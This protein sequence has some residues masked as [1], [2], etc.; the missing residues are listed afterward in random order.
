MK[1][2]R[3][4]VTAGPTREHFDPVRFISNPSSGKMGAA[5]ARA[6]LGLGWEVSLVMGPC[7]AEAPEGAELVRVTSA[8]DMLRETSARFDS[9]DMLIMTAAVSD[10]RPREKSPAKVKKESLSM[11]VEFEPTP[12]I[13]KT[14]SARKTG[15]VLVGFAA[16]TNDV[17]AYAR[18][19]LKSKNLDAIAANSVASP[20]SG[21]A[22]DF[23][24]ITLIFKDGEEIPLPLAPKPELAEAMAAI[25]ARKF[26]RD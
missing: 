26:F 7:G 20:D 11:T 8:E 24:A 4:L 10:M 14:L 21:F 19:K 9:C 16:E 25:L 15:Q 18:G 1:K 13:L 3:C 5:L 6:C 23:N 22:S 12:D 17:L 2:V